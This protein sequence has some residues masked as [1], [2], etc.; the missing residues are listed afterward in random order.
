ME[1]QMLGLEIHVDGEGCWPDIAEK[2][3]TV[4]HITN[5][6]QIAGL[7]GGLK[8]GKPSVAIRIDLD[9]NEVV[10]AETSLVL[11]LT[12]ADALK[13]RYGDPRK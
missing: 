8:S 3:M 10:F 7:P 13:A 1:D 11:F 12:A 9:D 4:R 5:G 2:K 6:M